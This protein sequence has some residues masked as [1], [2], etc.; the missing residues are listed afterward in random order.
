MD[1]LVHVNEAGGGALGVRSGQHKH[2]GILISVVEPS[3]IYELALTN[4]TFCLGYFGHEHGCFT[5]EL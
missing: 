2:S 1:S 5:E 4:L 3:N